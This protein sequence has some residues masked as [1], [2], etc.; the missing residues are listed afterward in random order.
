MLPQPTSWW[1]AYR[2]IA[3]S[4]RGVHQVTGREMCTFLAG[5]FSRR[6]VLEVFDGLTILL[7]VRAID[8][9]VT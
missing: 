9:T 3:T 6:T 1:N 5:E 7:K 8:A 4:Q 2:F